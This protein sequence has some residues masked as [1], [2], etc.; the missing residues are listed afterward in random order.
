MSYA[1]FRRNP[2]G[3]F[4]SDRKASLDQQKKAAVVK[5]I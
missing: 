2:W 4:R 1:R 5:D 3:E